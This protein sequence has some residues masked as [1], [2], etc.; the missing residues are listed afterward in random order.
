MCATAPPA[1]LRHSPGCD[2][3]GFR[4]HTCPGGWSSSS[5]IIHHVTFLCLQT[6][7]NNP[8]DPEIQAQINRTII[9]VWLD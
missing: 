9:Q 3:V 8:E 5:C 1:R 4:T 6:D 7:P 2:T